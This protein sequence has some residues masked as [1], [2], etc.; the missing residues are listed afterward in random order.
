MALKN[1]EQNTPKFTL[2]LFCILCHNISHSKTQLKIIGKDRFFLTLMIY[3]LFFLI[4]FFFFCHVHTHCI[5]I[6]SNHIVRWGY[7][8]EWSYCPGFLDAISVCW[9][10]GVMLCCLANR[11][12]YLFHF[13][14]R[15]CNI[16]NTD[17]KVFV[18]GGMMRRD[19]LLTHISSTVAFHAALWWNQSRF[20][21]TTRQGTMEMNTPQIWG[22]SRRK[23]RRGWLGEGREWTVSTFRTPAVLCFI[24]ARERKPSIL[25]APGEPHQTKDTLNLTGS[26]LYKK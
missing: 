5:N 15:F 1:N 7:L 11:L 6:Q 12:F 10:S 26:Q 14:P 17:N 24:C 23:G 16:F 22:L 25:P 20:V 4:F 18:N 21:M 19:I 9:S 2:Q 3:L 8:V 13:F